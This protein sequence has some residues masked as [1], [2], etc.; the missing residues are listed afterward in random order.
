LPDYD[1]YDEYQDVYKQALSYNGCVRVK[2]DCYGNGYEV[3]ANGLCE[4]K[5][6][7]Q[8]LQSF[9]FDHGEK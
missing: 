9:V 6:I 2:Q 4:Q 5:V 3:D 8:L 7:G 1:S